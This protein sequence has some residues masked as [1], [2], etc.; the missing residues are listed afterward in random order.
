M[1]FG[2]RSTVD[3]HRSG[4]GFGEDSRGGNEVGIRLEFLFLSGVM[5]WLWCL[6]VES[7]GLGFRWRWWLGYWW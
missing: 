2:G 1:R 4:D 7:S 5:V 3:V 6:A